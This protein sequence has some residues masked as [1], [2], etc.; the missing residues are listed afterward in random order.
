M[1]VSENDLR[2]ATLHMLERTR[3]LSS[4]P[5]PPARRRAQA[6][7]GR[8]EGRPDRQR[9]E[10]DARAAPRATERR[11]GSGGAWRASTPRC[12]T[13]SARPRSSASRTSAPSSRRPCW[14]SSSTSTPGG[15]NKDRIALSMIGRAEEDGRLRPRRDDRRATSGNTGVGLALAAAIKGYKMIFVVPT[16]SPRRRSRSCAPSAPRS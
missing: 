4:R 15:S 9:R 16:R 10:H 7:P 12:S 1:L 3:N 14:R 2:E 5:A 6:R 8:A 13:W 11:I